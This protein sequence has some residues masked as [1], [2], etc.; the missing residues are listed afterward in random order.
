M[1]IGENKKNI[2]ILFVDAFRTK[3]LSLYGYDKETDEN[4]KK[5][6]KEN[7]WFKNHF[8]VSNCTAPALTSVLTGK[9]P[10]NH[11]IIHQLP[12]TKPEGIE[13]IKQ[14]NFWLPSYLKT[15]GYETIGIDWI[16]LWF[17]RGFDYYEEGEKDSNS[18]FS[19]AY[20]MTELAISK[21]KQSQKPFFLFMHFWDTHFPFPN[22]KY[23][24]L[25][26]E[27]DLNKTLEKIENESQKEYLKKRLPKAGLYTILDIINKYD[28]SIQNIDKE[29]GRLYGFLKEQDLL[30]DTILIVLGDHG[31]NLTEHGIYFSSSSLYDE[32]VHVPLIMHLPGF[33]KKE[34]KGLVENIDITATLFDYLGL[35]KQEF[36]GKSFL[37]LLKNNQAIREQVFLIDGLCEDIKAIR[38][39]NKKLIIANNNFCNLCKAGHHKKIELY[40]L[41]KDPGEEENIYSGEEDLIKFL[42]E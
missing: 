29:I 42:F 26:K 40:D 22:T 10:Q 21:I 28:L 31:E 19:S 14:A 37:P 13:K 4:L 3:N 23:T 25:G 27:E 35:E 39:K 7:I 33:E 2:I 16:G 32:T 24:P 5:I 36:D 20:Q 6:A 34:V 41:D 30:K 11:G 1:D 12:Y 18:L 9:Y 15:K 38:T 17:T 8:S